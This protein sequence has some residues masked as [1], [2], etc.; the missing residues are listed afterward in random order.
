VLVHHALRNAWLPVI[1]VVGVQAGRW[2][3]G[4]VIVEVLFGL[5]GI[6]RLVVDATVDR[7]VP[8]IQGAVLVL[9]VG[10]VLVNLVV[11]L[12]YG[13]IDPRVRQA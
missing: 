9:V 5:P 6:G 2:L 7:D 12:L 11:D 4:A 13:L 3:G 8:M 10:V 1:T